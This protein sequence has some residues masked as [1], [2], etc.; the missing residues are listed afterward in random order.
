MVLG[1]ADWASIAAIV[2]A[3]CDV[4]ATGR[5][6]F[7]LFYQRRLASPEAPT[8]AD[9]LSKAFSTYSDE[10]VDAIRER[11][12]GCRRR[13]IEEGSGEQRKRCLCSVLTDVKDGNGGSI[14]I[15]DWADTYDQL[16]CGG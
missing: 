9:A 15:G 5:D 3:M 10:E 13:F 2:S 12:E 1:L 11:I 6:T 7:D 8:R 16:G 14:P 4:I